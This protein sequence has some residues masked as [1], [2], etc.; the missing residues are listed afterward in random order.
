MLL[1]AAAVIA[2]DELASLVPEVRTSWLLVVSAVQVNPRY[3]DRPGL[4][5]RTA[6]WMRP[7]TSP[8]FVPRSEPAAA[9]LPSSCTRAG[10]SPLMLIIKLLCLVSGR[11]SRSFAA[12]ALLVSVPA[13]GPIRAGKREAEVAG[14]TAV[15]LDPLV[16]L[17]ELPS[18]LAPD[19]LLPVLPEPLPEL[20]DPLAPV[21]AGG[22]GGGG[23]A[24]S[25]TVTS[26]ETSLITS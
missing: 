5:A 20:P 19:P 25:L 21:V 23:G 2:T 11:V 3:A 4:S 24:T 8:S 18:A 1:L 7:A 9:L 15:L 10:V 6:F 16:A 12:K 14:T 22:V 13:A 17:P 26:C